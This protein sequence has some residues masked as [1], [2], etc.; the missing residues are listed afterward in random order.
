MEILK[1]MKMLRGLGVIAVLVAAGVAVYLYTHRPLPPAVNDRITVYYTKPDG[2]GLVPYTVTRG[3]ANDPRSLA[4]LAATQAVAGPPNEIEAT[5]FPA[6]TFVRSVELLGSTAV[7]D[8]SGSVK[9]PV[10]GSFTEG[11]MFKALVWTLT[12]RPGI[13][14]VQVKIDGERVE[15]LP[16]GHLELDVPL[17]RSDW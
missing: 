10:E 6:G 15:T 17:K 14:D 7:V 13:K 2:A 12:E 9:Q 11:G 4:F 3:P 5:R 8:L 16:G 1:A